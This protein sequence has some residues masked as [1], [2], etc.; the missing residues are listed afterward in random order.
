MNLAPSQI[1]ELSRYEFVC[2]SNG[3]RW[4][5]RRDDDK[6]PVMDDLKLAALGIEGFA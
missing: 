5:N 1:N 3:F 6:P 4:I 2:M